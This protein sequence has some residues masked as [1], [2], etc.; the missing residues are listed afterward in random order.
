MQYWYLAVND[1]NCYVKYPLSGLEMS[2]YFIRI[3]HYLVTVLLEYLDL[4]NAN[5]ASCSCSMFKKATL[6]FLCQNIIYD[7]DHDN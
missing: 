5:L 2:E 7:Y 3:F 1:T 4:F 6:H